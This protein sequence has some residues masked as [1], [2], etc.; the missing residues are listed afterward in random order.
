MPRRRRCRQI[1]SKLPVSAAVAVSDV[2]VAQLKTCWRSDDVRMR[3]MMMKMMRSEVRSDVRTEW[4]EV[5]C[6]RDDASN[7]DA[8]PSCHPRWTAVPAA[9]PPSR[10]RLPPSTDTEP[11]GTRDRRC[12]PPIAELWRHAFGNG[13]LRLACVRWN[14]RCWTAYANC[15]G[16]QIGLADFCPCLFFSL[17]R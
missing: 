11:P 2:D 10:S 6:V 16:V 14:R 9:G 7:S 5:M 8:G 12:R 4:S 3:R 17:V 1:C 15:Y 13:N